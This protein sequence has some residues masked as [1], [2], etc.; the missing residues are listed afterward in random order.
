MRRG[1]GAR[2]GVLGALA[3][4]LGTLSPTAV[5]QEELEWVALGDSYTAGIFAGPALAP[6]DGCERTHDAYPRVAARQLAADPAAR[7]VELTADVSCGG[8]AI[9]HIAEESQQPIGRNAPP[10]GWPAVPPQLEAVD[11]GTDVVSIG[12]GGNSMPFGSMLLNCLLIGGDQPDAAAPCADAYRNAPPQGDPETIDAKYAR[13]AAEYRSM[14]ASVSAAAPGAEIVTV[15]YPTLIPE[16]VSTCSR[17]DITEFSAGPLGSITHGDLAWLRGVSERL[18]AIVAEATADAGGRFVDV[19]TPSEGHDAC[20]DAGTKWIEGVCGP[21]ET[22][23][24]IDLDQV[25]LAAPEGQRRATLIHPNAAGHA[26]TGAQ[27][28]AAIREIVT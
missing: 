7:P 12:I 2:L 22:D 17:S 16:D 28:A 6:E 24:R 8:A 18:N 14:L 5:A 27:V 19:A 9:A 10:D 15:G 13:V 26:A 3:V 20:R 4:M 21:P 23:D 1:T 11:R 25:C